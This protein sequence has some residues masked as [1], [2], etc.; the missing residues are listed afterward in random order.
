MGRLAQ[1]LRKGGK[2]ILGDNDALQVTRTERR[3]FR[4][5]I[6]LVTK[7]CGKRRA[8]DANYG[9]GI[10]VGDD[11]ISYST[12]IYGDNPLVPTTTC[13]LDWTSKPYFQ[14]EWRDY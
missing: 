13:R 11:Y 10:D 8:D 4:H 12:K 9:W 5:H 1:I 2:P 3:I 7:Q 6:E 14:D